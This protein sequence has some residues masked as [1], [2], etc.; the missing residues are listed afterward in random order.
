MFILRRGHN[1]EKLDS[2][3]CQKVPPGGERVAPDTTRVVAYVLG[4][5]NW[6]PAS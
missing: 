1:V 2:V 4:F 6:H 3:Q 5:Q